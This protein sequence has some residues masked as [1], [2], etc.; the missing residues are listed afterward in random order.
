[1]ARASGPRSRPT[2]RSLIY[3]TREGAE[4]GLRLRDL[5]SGVER[6]LAFPVQRDNMEAVPDLDVLPG[7][8]FTPDGS[9]IVVSYG[10]EIWRVPVAGGAAV[11]IPLL[12]RRRRRGRSRGAGSTT[13]SR[14]RRRFTARQIRDP[15]TSPDGRRIAFTVL[16][17]LY[18]AD[19]PNGTPRRLTSDEVGE[20]FPAW[21]PDGSN[22]AY[23]SWTGDAGHVMR[24]SA[25][26]GAATAQVSTEAGLYFQ[27]VWSPDGSRILATRSPAREGAR[28]DRSLRLPGHGD[29]SSS[30][31][32]RRADPRPR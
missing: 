15:V 12:G 8:S 10:G 1:M 9:A 6:W 29:R 23:V 17:R 16:D 24:V 27:P 2:A 25:A 3:G 11:K 7:Y 13:R 22:I 4:T 30:G 26:G 5:A 20:Y 19:L 21:S 31:S 32:R 28:G 18:V 14:T